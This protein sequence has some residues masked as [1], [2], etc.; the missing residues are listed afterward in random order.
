MDYFHSSISE[1]IRV[2]RSVNRAWNSRLKKNYWNKFELKY[3][4]V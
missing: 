2:F 4:F 3:I 1:N